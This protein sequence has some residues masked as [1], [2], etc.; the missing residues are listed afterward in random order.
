MSKW[1]K[2]VKTF[3]TLEIGVYITKKFTWLPIFS[4]DFASQYKAIFLPIFSADYAS[5]YRADFSANLSTDLTSQ[6]GVNFLAKIFCRFC[7]ITQTM[8]YY[9]RYCSS[10][11][12]K[13]G[14]LFFKSLSNDSFS[15][16]QD[17]TVIYRMQ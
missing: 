7:S 6:D 14:D 13:I 11:N 12:A 17:S 15:E 9:P 16:F 3:L 10:M 4:A 1:A 5:Q 2:R 8:K